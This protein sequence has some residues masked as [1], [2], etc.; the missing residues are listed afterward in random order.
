[1]LDKPY[2]D[3]ATRHSSS[4]RTVS[5]RHPT[6][7]RTASS[8]AKLALLTAR[9][10]IPVNLQYKSNTE[11]YGPL[12][13]ELKAMEAQVEAAEEARER[14]AELADENRRLRAALYDAEDRADG[15]RREVAHQ[16]ER[17][18]DEDA[19]RADQQVRVAQHGRQPA[20][21]RGEGRRENFAQDR[22]LRAGNCAAAAH[23]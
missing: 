18:E 19:E 20:G 8:P 1:M 7:T 9:P 11:E 12:R 6:N 21:Q 13:K 3:A 17:K 16:A 23:S 10:Q 5:S 15:E 14:N 22:E 2:Q 4:A